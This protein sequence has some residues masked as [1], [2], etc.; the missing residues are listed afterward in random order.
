M[1]R[2]LTTASEVVVKLEGQ[3]NNHYQINTLVK[4]AHVGILQSQVQL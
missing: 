2:F 4:C 1:L 3:E